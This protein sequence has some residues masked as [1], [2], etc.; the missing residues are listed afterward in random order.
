MLIR[1]LKDL[2]RDGWYIQCRHFFSCIPNLTFTLIYFMTLDCISWNYFVLYN[3]IK[4]KKAKN[5]EIEKYMTTIKYSAKRICMEHL[6]INMTKKETRFD[7]HWNIFVTSFTL[8]MNFA[9][10]IRQSS[11]Y[12]WGNILELAR[13]KWNF[14]K[15]YVHITVIYN[16]SKK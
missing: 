3:R 1:H 6:Y 7:Y 14:D 5:I 16:F 8:S 9:K 12:I 10:V 13:Y 2:I 11:L 4:Y 15:S